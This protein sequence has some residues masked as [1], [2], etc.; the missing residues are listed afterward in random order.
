MASTTQYLGEEILDIKETKFAGNTPIDWALYFITAYGG[1]GGSH[2]KDWVLDQAARCLHGTVP[3][4]KLA[5]WDD[6][7]QEFRVTLYEVEP[8][9][10][11][12]DWVAQFEGDYNEGIAP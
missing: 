2:H 9:K 7:Q 6:G 10:S 1:I 5:R 8:T 3:I 11:Y 12:T 4:V